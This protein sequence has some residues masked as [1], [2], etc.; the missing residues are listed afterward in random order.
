M[1]TDLK[2]ILL[3]SPRLRN[4][5][6]KSARLFNCSCVLCG[7]S[8]DHPKKARGYFFEHKQRMW[9]KCH[10]CSKSMPFSNFLRRFDATMY[11]EYRN[12][13]LGTKY[14]VRK[15]AKPE[16]VVPD[17]HSAERLKV[18]IRNSKVLDLLTPFDS[19]P[20]Q[21]KVYL[22]N[23]QLPD[24]ILHKYFFYAP[25]FKWFTNSLVRDKFSQASLKYDEAR[26]VILFFNE[27]D[28]ITGFQGREIEES[29]A[30]YVTIKFNDD[31]SKIF[32]RDRI[33]KNKPV[34]VVEGPI[35]SLFLD[36]GAGACGGDLVT[37][38]QDEDFDS[39]Y[40]FDNEPRK[41]EIVAKMEKAIEQGKK[42][43]I[44]PSYIIENDIND[45][46]KAGINVNTLLK[47][48]TY[49]SLQARMK[50]SMWRKR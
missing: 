27:E 17:S 25:R 10:K 31:D 8:K 5:S 6:K 9:Y 1:I 22:R 14:N 12:E 49:Q 33:D 21:L 35:D 18:G 23:R 28:K 47:Q 30:K 15:P 34:Y 19:M 44:F 16:L 36:N 50:F 20:D 46:V 39:V 26:I 13:R 3:L 40:V 24:D 48:N 41:K 42:I 43:V 32:G 4:F 38:T 45:M 2:Y 37:Q 29:Y 7:D 11:Q